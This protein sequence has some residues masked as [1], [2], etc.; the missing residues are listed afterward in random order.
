MADI[1]KGGE[2]LCDYSH[3]RHII[4][5]DE[6]RYN[7]GVAD[8]NQRDQLGVVRDMFQF[9]LR[10][11]ISELAKQAIR[12]TWLPDGDDEVSGIARVRAE[13]MTASQLVLAE[14]EKVSMLDYLLPQ[15]QSSLAGP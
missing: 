3:P 15:T 14:S 12:K 13:E 5:E 1:P 2:I 10:G 6:S 8:A 9:K 7:E 4:Q 11:A